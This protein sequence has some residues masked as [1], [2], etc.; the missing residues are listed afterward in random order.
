MGHRVEHDAFEDKAVMKVTTNRIDKT[1]LTDFVLNAPQPQLELKKMKT[2]LVQN[3]RN[4]SLRRTSES[5]PAFSTL[6]RVSADEPKL[7][8]EVYM[9][10]QKLRV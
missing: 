6:Q 4:S 9:Q 1:N 5:T 3:K 8:V 10:N 2:V 7:K